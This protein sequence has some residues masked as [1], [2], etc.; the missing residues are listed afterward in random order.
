MKKIFILSMA[1]LCTK[2]S[3]GQYVE[4]TS[5]ETM[6]ANYVPG[7][8][9]FND[10]GSDT[11]SAGGSSVFGYGSGLYG[12]YM[13]VTVNSCNDPLLGGNPGF[14]WE[15]S[16]FGTG[17]SPLPSG[18]LDP[19]VVLVSPATSNAVWAI[20]VYYLPSASG[21]C[22]STAQL[23]GGTFTPMSGPMFIQGYLPGGSNPPAHINIDSDNAG[24]FGVVLQMNGHIRSYSSTVAG[25]P[26]VP[27]NMRMDAD[28]IEPDIAFLSNSIHNMNIIALNDSRSQYITFTRNY[29]GSLRYS[30]HFSPILPEMYEPRIAAPSSGFENDYSITVL[31]KHAI[32]PNVYFDVLY[33]SNEIV[34]RV[35]N[36]TSTL[37]FGINVNNSNEFPAL[38][39]A[40]EGVGLNER[41]VLGWWVDHLL[42]AGALPNQQHSFV[43]VDV[44]TAGAVMSSP[45]YYMDIS[46]MNGF[47]NVS[48]IALSGRFSD[49]SKNAAF[50]YE[51]PSLPGSAFSLMWKSQL[52]STPN[53]K[54]AATNTLDLAE[55]KLF[56]NPATEQ[57]YVSLEGASGVFS[58]E[59]YSQVGRLIESGDLDSD[60]SEITVSDWAS[61]VY[62]VA[63]KNE[64]TNST[65]MIRFV[66][67]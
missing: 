9:S 18:A 48:T 16:I 35:A 59:V 31:R 43:G 46:N 39:Y 2:F 6:Y 52:T 55:I 51:D 36:N 64:E 56:P 42:P 17:N 44:S 12:N 50:T 25:A 10:I 65:K 57:A 20:A 37:P 53:W 22:M 41:V 15:S 26:A 23:A 19:D 29:F 62:L 67:Q 38:T 8:C 33:E 7:T 45:T 47:N 28:L 54:I 40:Y 1:M 49:W 58:Y 60:K 30:D 4:G 34:T 32:G 66:K 13:N 11:R 5:P 63:V 14:Y 24:H 21:Y 27:G 61:G 3:I